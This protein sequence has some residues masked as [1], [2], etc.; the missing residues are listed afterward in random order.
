MN[1]KLFDDIKIKEGLVNIIRFV[2]LGDINN[3]PAKLE[4]SDESDIGLHPPVATHILYL[5]LYRF[6][7][8]FHSFP[9]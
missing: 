4:E 1:C 9:H 5:M 2:D 8:S 7:F 3:I 6:M